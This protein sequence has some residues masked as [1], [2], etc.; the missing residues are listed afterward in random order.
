MRARTNIQQ[1]SWITLED[2]ETTKKWNVSARSLRDIRFYFSF[3][4]G[5]YCHCEYQFLFILVFVGGFFRCLFRFVVDAECTFQTA[6]Q[7]LENFKIQLKNIFKYR[8]P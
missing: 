1:T 2:L 5:D 7:N 8:I 3:W 4:F 6:K